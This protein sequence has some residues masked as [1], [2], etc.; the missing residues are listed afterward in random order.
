M[1]YSL[2]GHVEYFVPIGNPRWSSTNFF[3]CYAN[4]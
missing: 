2:N 1:E 4:Q 3:F